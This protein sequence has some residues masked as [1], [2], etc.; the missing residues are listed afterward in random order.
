MN[1]YLILL[2][3]LINCNNEFISKIVVNNNSQLNY[4]NEKYF[5]K[6]NYISRYECEHYDDTNNTDEFQND[7]YNYAL[8]LTTT[9]TSFLHLTYS[10]SANSSVSNETF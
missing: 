1:T 8:N 3:L 4:Y 9:L 2:L 7:V 6:N 10:F 5:I